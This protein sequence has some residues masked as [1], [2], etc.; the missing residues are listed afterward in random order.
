MVVAGAATLFL[1]LI[2]AGHAQSV[3]KARNMELG[4]VCSLAG[5]AGEKSLRLRLKAISPA[6]PARNQGARVYSPPILEVFPG[7]GS[8]RRSEIPEGYIGTTTWTIVPLE[9]L[10]MFS[11]P[12]R[13]LARGHASNAHSHGQQL[14]LTWLT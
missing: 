8:L 12:P 1:F 10:R 5:R 2:R 14:P 13:C 4:P 7:L 6:E 3:R 11:L 9:R